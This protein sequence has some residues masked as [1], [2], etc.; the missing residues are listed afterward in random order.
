MLWRSP[1]DKAGDRAKGARRL[2]IDGG[3]TYPRGSEDRHARM[4]PDDL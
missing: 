3:G 2:D 1:G 4:C